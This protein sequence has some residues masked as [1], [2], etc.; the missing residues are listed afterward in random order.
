MKLALPDKELAQQIF[1]LDEF[2][3]KFLRGVF[4]IEVGFFKFLLHCANVLAWRPETA[5]H[6][7]QLSF[8]GQKEVDKEQGGVGIG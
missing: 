6:D 2:C 3:F 4:L 7:Q 8:L 1:P 5:L